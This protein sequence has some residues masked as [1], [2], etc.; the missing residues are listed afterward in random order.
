MWT[1][2]FVALLFALLGFSLGRARTLRQLGPV[3][4]E[5]YELGIENGKKQV[6]EGGYRA[7]A[8]LPP[9]P[10]PNPFI[11]QLTRISRMVA[12]A[13]IWLHEDNRADWERRNKR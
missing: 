13:G 7:P 9:A 6:T 11:E 8:A 1:A 3:V 12:S 10:P 4:L 5:A 2:L